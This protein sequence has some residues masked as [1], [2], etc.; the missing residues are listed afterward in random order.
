MTRHAAWDGTNENLLSNNKE[1]LGFDHPCEPWK[2][3]TKSIK[4]VTAP[5]RPLQNIFRKEHKRSLNTD[6]FAEAL[7]KRGALRNVI[8]IQ[9]S[10]N[11]N[12]IS[13]EFGTKQMMENFCT[14]PLEIVSFTITFSPDTKK[15]WPPELLNISFLNVPPETPENILTEYVNEYADIKGF[16]F[17]PKKSA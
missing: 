10:S 12:F 14:E 8:T 15:H 7:L 6:D 1:D 5:I 3:L 9:I 16:P 11:Q 13:I 4:T 2:N 17:Y